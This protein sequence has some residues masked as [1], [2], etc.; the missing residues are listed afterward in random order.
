MFSSSQRNTRS[1]LW[2]FEAKM[3]FGAVKLKRSMINVA[4][5]DSEQNEHAM[6]FGT[7]S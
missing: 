5:Q 2:P 3:K 4:R 7:Q 6:A 1:S